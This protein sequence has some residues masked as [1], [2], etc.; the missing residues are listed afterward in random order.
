[1]ISYFFSLPKLK[2]EHYL[3]LFFFLSICSCSRSERLTGT[4]REILTKFFEELLLEHGGAYTLL[5][6]KPATVEDLIDMSPENQKKIRQYLASHPEIPAIEIDRHLEEGWEILQ[7]KKV[8]ISEKF[9]F[10][11]VNYKNYNL[12]VFLNVDLAISALM[13]HDSEIKRISDSDFDPIALIEDLRTGKHD[14]WRQIFDDFVCQGILLGYGLKN[15]ILFQDLY[16]ERVS[17]SLKEEYL[18]SENNDPRLKA[19]SDLNGV[20]FRIPIFVMFD[21]KESE[22]LVANYKKERERIR[23]FY[24]GKDFLDTTLSQLKSG[25]RH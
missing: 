9:V 6:S 17:G 5:G 4:D 11:Q 1:M 13:K 10:T 15:G 12:L 16:K 21:K 20:P 3:I 14:V 2:R 22:N 8:S 7:R 24:S 25:C 19:E 18:P 23:E